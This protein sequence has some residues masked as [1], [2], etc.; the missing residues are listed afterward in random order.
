MD[1]K[2]DGNVIVA[3]DRALDVTAEIASIP[4]GVYEV[5]YVTGQVRIIGTEHINIEAAKAA[6]DEQLQKWSEEEQS[7]H[8][9]A[10]GRP[11]DAVA[12]N[13]GTD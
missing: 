11:H 7:D 12:G 5:S 3:R 6:V 13:D 1:W 8:G 4:G 10:E 2:A 9:V